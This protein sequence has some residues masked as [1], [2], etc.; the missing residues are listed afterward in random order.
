MEVYNCRMNRL[1]RRNATRG[2]GRAAG[3]LALVALMGAPALADNTAALL[4]RFFAPDARPL[5]SYRAFR[6]MTA[7]TRGGKMSATI[8]AWTSLD[9]SRGF[10][11]EITKA[12]GSG[13]IQKR[14]LIKALE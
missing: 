13:L 1:T 11:W 2:A 5:V 8:E 3:S 9:P 12:E 10:T 7:S 14:V 6:H 4:Q